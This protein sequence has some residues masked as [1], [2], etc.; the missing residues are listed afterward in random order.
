MGESDGA[1]KNGVPKRELALVSQEF[2]RAAFGSR[3]VG[4]VPS[5]DLLAVGKGLSD[6]LRKSAKGKDRSE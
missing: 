4:S 6:A 2:V 5:G 1:K 3:V